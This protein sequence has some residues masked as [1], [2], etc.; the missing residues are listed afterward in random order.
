VRIDYRPLSLLLAALLVPSAAAA[1]AP[2]T[3]ITDV[4]RVGLTIS[5]YGSFG[6]NFVTRSPSFEFPLGT[7][8]E[9]LPLGGFWIGALTNVGGNDARLVSTGAFDAVQGQST[10]SFTE[11]KPL[12]D[13]VERSRQPSSPHY[14]PLAVSDQDFVTR[15]GDDPGQSAPSGSELHVPLGLEVRQETFGW[16]TPPLADI[17]FVRLTLRATRALLREAFVGLYAQLASGPKN[18]YA[19]WPPTSAGGG[20]L[21]SWYSK[22][23]LAW[24][25]PRRLLAEHYCRAAGACDAEVVPPWA[26]I[27]LLGCGPDPVSALQTGLQIW[28][29]SPGDTAR[30]TDGKKYGLLASPHVTPADSLPPG[31]T[32]DSQLNDPSELL[33]VGPFT[34]DPAVGL[35]EPSSVH[36]DFAILGGDTYDALLVN[37][38]RAHLVFDA[39]YE[40]PVTA[41]RISFA[42]F[43]VTDDGVVVRWYTPD[44]AGQTARVC[45]R[46]GNDPRTT[47]ADVESDGTG[48]FAYTDRSAVPGTRYAYDLEIGGEFVGEAWI[49][50]PAGTGLVFVAISPNPS[51]G[52][53]TVAFGIPEGAP[54]NLALYDAAGRCVRRVDGLAPG[55]HALELGSPERLKPGVYLMRLEQGGEA[56]S[57][58]A[59]VLGQPIR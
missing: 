51:G 55:R 30:N 52:Q 26:G 7:G 47:L 12:A 48:L 20:S 49:D 32:S 50:V 29:W 31:G 46:S 41:T 16:N 24:D 11:F 18:L 9:H 14:D 37:A 13:F 35:D 59:I 8:Y 1:Q 33:T 27:A 3:R 4:H 45:R 6:N 40:P 28:N 22:K 43:D 39:H 23:L 36:V 44:G 34:V 10:T 56:V 57:R 21:G 53:F 5:N 25:A 38:D 58:K 2:A 54:A 17:V 15:Y 42:D 19:S